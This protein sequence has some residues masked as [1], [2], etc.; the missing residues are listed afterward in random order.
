MSVFAACRSLL[1]FAFDLVTHDLLERRARRQRG[2]SVQKYCTG[3]D[4]GVA[5]VRKRPFR[6]IRLRM[7]ERVQMLAG[8]VI[9]RRSCRPS[10]A[11]WSACTLHLPYVVN[12][13]SM[14]VSSSSWMTSGRPPPVAYTCGS[15]RSVRSSHDFSQE[16][17]LPAASHDVRYVLRVLCA[18]GL[19]EA[20]R[21][22][23]RQC[24]ATRGGG[25]D[26]RTI[27][28]ASYRC[29]DSV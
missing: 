25:M 8:D 21:R 23:W 11:D 3:Y 13:K 12:A 4:I 29:A 28:P 24:R 2:A 22:P 5:C 14:C 18:W 27:Y 10:W 6:P 26:A 17:P 20:S 9:T 15:M 19:G 16:S 7:V 1:P